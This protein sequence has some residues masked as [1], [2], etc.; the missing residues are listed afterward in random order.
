M[1]MN[2]FVEPVADQRSRGPDRV[3]SAPLGSFL[4]P[5]GQFFNGSRLLFTYVHRDILTRPS[6]F[7]G[8]KSLF[9]S[10]ER[11]GERFRFGMDPSD[12]PQYLAERGLSLEL[13]IGAAE[14]RARYFGAEAPNILGHEFYRVALARVGQRAA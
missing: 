5:M 7:V 10:L 12:V 8:T 3:E 2:R 4:L 14:Y 6:A 9:T 13:D 1:G 11:A